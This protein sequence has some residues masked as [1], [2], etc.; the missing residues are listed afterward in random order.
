L[1]LAANFELILNGDESVGGHVGVLPAEVVLQFIV[2]ICP[3]P[4]RTNEKDVTWQSRNVTDP[5]LRICMNFAA[6]FPAMKLCHI[7]TAPD[8]TNRNTPE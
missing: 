6:V 2:C 1:R 3:P 8:K 5:A 4:V 7:V